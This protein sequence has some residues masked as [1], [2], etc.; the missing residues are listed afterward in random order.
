[1]RYGP[2][3]LRIITAPLRWLAWTLAVVVPLAVLGLGLVYVKLLFGTIPLHFL[4]EPV[5]EALAAELGEVDVSITDAALHRSSTGGFELRLID[6][7][8]AARRGDTAVRAAE[9]V[10]GLDLAAL[11]SG[12]IAADRIVLIG[13][14]LNLSQEMARLSGFAPS[15]DSPS[16]IPGS[17]GSAPL[18]GAEGATAPPMEE[19]HRIDLART[20]A[21]AVAHLREG[22]KAA[23]QLRAFGLRNAT[24]EIDDHGRRSVWQV[25]EMEIE[26]DHHSRR[27][28][29]KGEGRISAGGMPFGVSFV[30]DQSGK[31]RTL[32]LATTIEGLSLP[33]LAR[34]VPHLGLLAAIDAPVTARGETEL[35]SDGTV[36]SGRFDVDLGHGS[37]LPE[38][39]GGMAIG[40]DGGKLALLYDGSTRRL[41]L[42]PSNVQLDGSWLRIKGELKP[43]SA[44]GNTVTG[45]QL[46]L[47]SIDGALAKVA[48]RPAAR[49][50]QLE[51]RARLWPASGASELQSFVFKA[52]GADLRAHGT[53]IGG[54]NRSAQLD[55]RIGPMDA[56][57]IRLF[58][59]EAISP[60]LRSA[61]L[62]RL[63]KGRLKEG[64]FQIA[65]GK[66]AAATAGLSLSLEAE[67]LSIRP[68]P[69]LPPI[70]I[71]SALL[72]RAGDQLALVAPEGQLEIAP[73]R[74][75]TIKAASV[76]I[77]G[78]D[79]EQPE[80]EISG[81]AQ[82]TL[83][84]VADLLGRESIA[85]ID[86]GQVP[87][88]T[89]GKVEAQWRATVPVTEGLSLADAKLDAKIRITDGR[90]PNV[91]GPHD[92]TSAA[93]TIGATERTVDL[94]GELLLAGVIAKANGQWILGESA[95]HQSPIVVTARLDNADRRRLGLSMDDLVQGEVPLEVQ[96]TPGKGD[97]GRVVVNGD[98]TPAELTLEGL[99]WA[100][101]AGRAARLSF[102]VVRPQGGRTVE[103]QNFRIS[104]DTITANGT[105]VFGPD[106]KLSSYRFPGFSI[107]VVSNLELEGVRRPDNVWNVK[108]RG[109]TFDGMAIMRSLY[110]FEEKR[111]S[112]SASDPLDLDARIDT[113]IGHNDTTVR[114]LRL[115]FQRRDKRIVGL[116][117]NA[118]LDGGSPIEARMQSV[119]D[120]VMHVE[121]HDA[122]QALK[123]IG[124][125]ASMV[126]GRGDLWVDLDGSTGIERSGRIKIN[127]FRILG[128]PVVSELVQGADETGPAIAIGK[129]RPVRRVVREEIVFDSLRGSFA[130]G[131]GQ[132]AI[133]SL[134]AAGPL[135]GASVRGKMDFRTR[136]VSLGGTYVP[137]SGLNRV[138]AGIPI[139][140]ELLTGPRKDGV[141]GI[142]FA[143]DGSMANPNVIINPLSMVAP[144]VLRE[145]FQM[146]PDNPRV[147]PVDG[148]A[149]LGSGASTSRAAGQPEPGRQRKR[150][151]TG[152]QVLDGWSSHSTSV[153]R[154]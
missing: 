147:T 149:P 64:K 6:V 95:E 32:K 59:P 21:E 30:V 35:T 151:A 16:A 74:R 54:E 101:P 45:W 103:L 86:P 44:A 143:V 26:L 43:V 110:A 62:Q 125:Y 15:A 92:V 139:F 109:K 58:W 88:G 9:A 152:P 68:M 10:V 124:F 69:D 115:K 120:G 5:R 96:I 31:T 2:T 94:K 27:S 37:I 136:S 154:R 23:S 121:T 66:A 61:V 130:T 98:L 118:T 97:R 137:L 20:V 112:A 84:T 63:V 80:A 29:I 148:A 12:R 106:G 90:I 25:D 57:T 53:M 36:V 82:S 60:S 83:A 135:I 76:V 113:V 3:P 144:G 107:N 72:T 131:N 119:Q 100:K 123:T 104:G 128:D 127:K 38:A 42:A 71:P 146:V 111:K 47:A 89:D 142:T 85:L 150:P 77:T 40:I 87:A 134:T 122:G 67:D 141:I 132:V 50:D 126:G 49:I 133:E 17:S 108:V 145:I 78:L 28:I 51:L 102:E 1:M 14:R 73:N 11:K 8:L 46:D 34:N 129:E 24:L 56:E 52:G 117:M 22:R 93:F 114:Q 33:A 79:K 55:G 39:L 19:P 41:E 153:E 99:S 48:G 140:G 65:S 138:L 116:E 70:T 4:V 81:R 75:V 18:A 91:V 13:P 105:L 7:S